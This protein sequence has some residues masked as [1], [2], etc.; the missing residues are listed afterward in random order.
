MRKKARKIIQMSGMILLI[1]LLSS[2]GLFHPV[3]EGS[4][5]EST[6]HLIYPV[7]IIA[8]NTATPEPVVIA[9]DPVHNH[10]PLRIQFDAPENME[11]P[12]FYHR[13][14]FDGIPYCVYAY[15]DVSNRT[16]FRV[17]AEVDELEDKNITGTLSG[18]SVLK[19]IRTK[20]V[21]SVWKPTKM[22]ILSLQKA[23]PPL[24]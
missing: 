7:Q 9:R 15:T 18:F 11:I 12:G 17:F 5:P 22:R 4:A 23:K 19:S 10:S 2:C 16:V 3:G 1:P 21:Y 13:I 24:L 14:D 6:V 20:T 8:E